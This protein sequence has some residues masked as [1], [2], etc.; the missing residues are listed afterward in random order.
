MKILYR[1]FKKKV[2]HTVLCF[3]IL[4]FLLQ[5]AGFFKI[6]LFWNS[7]RLLG[8]IQSAKPGFL[9]KFFF[10]RS[11]EKKS[12]E[13]LKSTIKKNLYYWQL[14]VHIRNVQNINSFSNQKELVALLQKTGFTNKKF[15]SFFASSFV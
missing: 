5:K 4:F 7:I 10:S 13:K 9:K 12:G 11:I 15:F 3:L 14:F 2:K 8:S 1:T 6:S